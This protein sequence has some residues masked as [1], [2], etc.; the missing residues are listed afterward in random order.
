MLLKL[1]VILWW[2]FDWQLDQQIGSSLLL[3]IDYQAFVLSTVCLASF[4]PKYWNNMLKLT[5]QKKK[6]QKLM[7]LLFSQT[8]SYYIQS[9]M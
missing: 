1:W 7:V 9:T 6:S 5:F 2:F 3:S 8:I 4:S